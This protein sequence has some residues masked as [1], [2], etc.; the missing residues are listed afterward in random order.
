MV[1]TANCSFVGLT[2]AP[3]SFPKA[4]ATR[5]VYFKCKTRPHFSR[6]TK[7]LP[8]KSRQYSSPCRAD[9]FTIKEINSQTRFQCNFLLV[10]LFKVTCFTM[11]ALRNQPPLSHGTTVEA[12][13]Q[14]SIFT[15]KNQEMNKVE[16]LTIQLQM[17]TC[18]RNELHG[19]LTHYT[20]NDLNSRSISSPSNGAS[21]GSN[22]PLVSCS[23]ASA[24]PPS[25]PAE[26]VP[27]GARCADHWRHAR[28][29]K[30]LPAS[31]CHPRLQEPAAQK[32]SGFQEDKA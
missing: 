31:S 22:P 23:P 14:F 12:L 26:S 21:A 32:V 16:K 29:N 5:S 27:S 17:M 15:E 25:S 10:P 8:K 28:H 6:A 7:S 18:E 19:S 30:A 24:C 3:N 1:L 11:P 4:A 13:T 9:L 2:V 20:N